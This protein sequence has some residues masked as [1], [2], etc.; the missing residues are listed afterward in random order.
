MSPCVDA[1]PVEHSEPEPFDLRCEAVERR[2]G[3]EPERSG[4]VA[5]LLRSARAAQREERFAEAIATFERAKRAAPNDAGV[6][7][8]LGWARFTAALACDEADLEVDDERVVC[9][10]DVT[11][12]EDDLTAAVTAAQSDQRRGILHYNLGQILLHRSQLDE[13]AEAFRLSECLRPNDTVRQALAE[14]WA[15]R[16]MGAWESVDGEGAVAALSFAGQLDES[17]REAAERARQSLQS[18]LILQRLAAPPEDAA[19][20]LEALCEGEPCELVG[21]WVEHDDWALAQLRIED[22]VA[23]AYHVLVA[24]TGRGFSVVGELG[25]EL[26]D[27]REGN[28]YVREAFIEPVEDAPFSVMSATFSWGSA[29]ADGCDW[30]TEAW[31]TLLLCA[32]HEGS[33]HCFASARLGAEVFDSDT[34]LPTAQESMGA[35]P[36]YAKPQVRDVDVAPTFAVSFTSLEMVVQRE[37]DEKLWCTPLREAFCEGEHVPTACSVEP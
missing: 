10:G 22:G 15:L 35:C 5:R 1:E 11:Q 32:H 20:G 34:M 8:E 29:M 17:R 27:S 16:A 25:S 18:G 7:G 14:V 13:A 31:V 24:R 19:E 12:A 6:L 28:G 2:Q 3:A 33:V 37:H 4:A 23:S 36:A 21:D 26:G 9:A 30:L